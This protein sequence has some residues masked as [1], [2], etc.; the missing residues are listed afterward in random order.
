[1]S[2]LHRYSAAT[3]SFG[4]RKHGTWCYTVLCASRC[5]AH[6]ICLDV[7]SGLGNIRLDVILGHISSAPSDLR[8]FHSLTLYTLLKGGQLQG[9]QAWVPCTISLEMCPVVKVADIPEDYAWRRRP[10]PWVMLKADCIPLSRI[11]IQ[12]LPS[13]SVTSGINSAPESTLVYTKYS[14]VLLNH[15]RRLQLSAQPIRGP[16]PRD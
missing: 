10:F 1:M 14:P 12:P 15:D 7:T 2:E 9:D 16:H 5:Y 6:E 8:A 13:V 3:I 4:I 11:A